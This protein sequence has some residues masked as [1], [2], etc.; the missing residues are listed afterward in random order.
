MLKLPKK[1]CLTQ[2]VLQVINAPDSVKVLGTLDEEG[3]P[4]LSP[5]QLLSVNDG[6]SLLIG[7]RLEKA[8]SNRNLVRS[9]WQEKPVSVYLSNGI[10]CYIV[11][12]SVWR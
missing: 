1:P 7:E 5:A 2:E 3:L 9:I 4:Y 10:Q 8:P 6:R 12:A 11:K